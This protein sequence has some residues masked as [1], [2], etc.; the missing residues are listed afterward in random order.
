M[1]ETPN[2]FQFQLFRQFTFQTNDQVL[3]CFFNELASQNINITGYMQA[4]EANGI[5]FVKVVVG[6]PSTQTASDLETTRS[7]LRSLGV[8]NREY[9]IIQVF[10]FPPVTPGVL[11]TLFGALWCKV[12]V[13]AMYV[14]EESLIFIDVNDIKKALR[15]LNQS[16]LKRCPTD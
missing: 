5:N 16:V 4:K 3:S 11:N 15:T 13:K 1:N 2:G 8:K 12:N 14:G 6:T 10:G 7:V 9:D